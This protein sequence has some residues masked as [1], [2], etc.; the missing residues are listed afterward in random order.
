MV[1]EDRLGL[2]WVMLIIGVKNLVRVALYGPSSLTI[3]HSELLKED[4][5]AEL[6]LY[7]I[8]A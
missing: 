3:H 6:F 2:F 5:T 1:F 7:W 8:T 4:W